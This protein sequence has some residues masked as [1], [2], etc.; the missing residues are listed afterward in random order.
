VKVSTASSR[1]HVTIETCPTLWSC[2]AAVLQCSGAA[3]H[4]P[5]SSPRSHFALAKLS[6][7]QHPGN[8][9]VSAGTQQMAWFVHYWDE[10]NKHNISSSEISSQEAAMQKACKLMQQGRVVSHV[11]GPNGERIDYSRYPQVV[12]GACKP[13]DATPLHRSVHHHHRRRPP[14]TPVS[15]SNERTDRTRARHFRE[16]EGR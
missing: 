6:E 8:I 13:L 2:T 12:L 11:A 16:Y 3:A 10:I 7:H 1:C 4:P 15:Q 14:A 9:V 5:L